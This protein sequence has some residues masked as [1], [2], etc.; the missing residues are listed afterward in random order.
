MFQ[1][2]HFQKM[3]KHL[4]MDSLSYEKEY[5]GFMAKLKNFHESKG[6]ADL[7]CVK[8]SRFGSFCVVPVTQEINSVLWFVV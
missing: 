3:A 6:W 1:P 7:T 4:G 2:S 8:V 5:N